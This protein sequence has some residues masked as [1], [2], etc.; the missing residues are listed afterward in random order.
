[1][2]NLRKETP[3][4]RHEPRGGGGGG[5][6]EN[7]LRKGPKKNAVVER[8]EANSNL[9][10]AGPEM[11]GGGPGRTLNG[12]EKK[13]GLLGP[14]LKNGGKGKRRKKGN[15]VT[16]D[17]PDSGKVLFRLGVGGVGGGLPPSCCGGGTPEGGTEHIQNTKR[18]QKISKGQNHPGRRLPNKIPLK[19]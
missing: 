1:V 6:R 5:D 13:R 15:K 14:V 3:L 7:A 4:V 16:V 17:N 12:G 18:G 10:V 19:D 2:E 11:T 9:T 8:G